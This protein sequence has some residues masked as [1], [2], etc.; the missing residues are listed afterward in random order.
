MMK[1][2]INDEIMC[3]NN[4]GWCSSLTVG[5][6]YLVYDTFGTSLLI[7]DNDYDKV[8]RYDR[9][10]MNLTHFELTGCVLISILAGL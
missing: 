2:E 7:I 10:F 9:R 4:I 6:S 3:I 8:W 5:K 1:F